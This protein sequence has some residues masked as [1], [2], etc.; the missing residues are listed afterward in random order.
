MDDSNLRIY[1]QNIRSLKTVNK[2]N[3]ELMNLKH[4]VNT[5]KSDFL[6]LVETWLNSNV[7]DK[8]LQVDGYNFFR[9]DR[10]SR[11]GG[12]LL[13]FKSSFLCTHR[14]DLAGNSVNFNEILFVR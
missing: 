5:Y 13:Y 7:L 11:G 6:C 8:E 12:V 10:G 14:M 2:D 1:F 9:R 4:F 3:N